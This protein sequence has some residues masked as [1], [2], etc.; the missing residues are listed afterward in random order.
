MVCV[1]VRVN[2]DV[3]VGVFVGPPPVYQTRTGIQS[4]KKSREVLLETLT[5]RTRRLALV[6]SLAFHARPQV[7]LELP[8]MSVRSLVDRF[9]PVF[10]VVQLVPLFHESWRQK[11][12]DPEVLS[13]RASVLTSIPVMLDPAGMESG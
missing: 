10:I 13:T 1:G 7:S 2:V 9:V 11:R 6:S 4:R 12:G 5:I 3:L 8:K